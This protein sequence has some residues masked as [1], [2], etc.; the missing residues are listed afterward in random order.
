MSLDMY[1]TYKS[2]MHRTLKC[3]FRLHSIGKLQ[4]KRIIDHQ[5]LLVVLLGT[6]VLG[7]L[8]NRYGFISEDIRVEIDQYEWI[9]RKARSANQAHSGQ[10]FNSSGYLVPNIVHFIWFAKKGKEM[11]FINYVSILSVHKFQRPDIIMFHCNELPSG[12]WWHKL[13]KLVPMKISYVQPPPTIYGQTL[14]HRY[15]QSDVAKLE[16]LMKYGGIYLDY[17]VILVQSLNPL[18]V[19]STIFGKEKGNKFNAGII[20][21]QK[22]A[23]FLSLV[24]RSYKNHY[25]PLDWDYNCQRVTYQIYLKFPDLV[26]VEPIRLTTP[27][28]TERHLLWTSQIKW[29]E[30]YL[31]HLLQH[32][33]WTNYSPEMIA[34]LNNTM[35]EVIR[36]V[37]FDSPNNV[38]LDH[39]N[40]K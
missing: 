2:D 35:G 23:L 1:I 38:V 25:R 11:T 40:N 5:Y 13:W 36:N 32:L 33:D 30:L 24:H 3:L 4:V 21:A 18:R 10:I 22:N 14:L 39:S 29:R 6:F 17:D 31:I 16:I 7:V 9:Q 12:E 27:D 37:Y 19:Y 20:I 28:W 26:H 34:Q 8:L 15:H